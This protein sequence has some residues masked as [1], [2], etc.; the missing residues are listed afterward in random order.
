MKFQSFDGLTLA[1]EVE[2]EGFPVLLLHGIVVDSFINFIRPGLVNAVTAAGFH[3]IA[4]DQRGHGASDKPHDAQAYA[5]GA[6]VRDARE[7]LDH[8]AIER[9][10]FVGYSMGAM[11]GLELIPQEPRIVAAVLGGVGGNTLMRRGSGRPSL[12]AEAMLAPDRRNVNEPGRSFRD[13][14]DL[15]KADREAIAAAS[16]GLNRQFAPGSI[17][18]PTLVVCGD[19]D[20][21]AGD[22]NELA[23]RIPGAEARIVGGSHLNVVNNPDFHEAIVGFLRE[24]VKGEG[25]T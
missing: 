21:L 18:V 6:L 4:L 15:V 7:L 8:L 9:C 16:Q 20:P 3:A 11:V 5:G 13:F 10:A 22:P 17:T 2:G 23:A 12:I 25:E 19:N 14:A 1:Y 24:R